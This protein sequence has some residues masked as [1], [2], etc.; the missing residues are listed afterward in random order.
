V[1]I[2]EVSMVRADVIDA[3]DHSLRINGNTPHLPFG[4]KQMIFVGDLFQL[5]PII[6]E[7]SE[8]DYI[9]KTYQYP[10][11]FQAHAFKDFKVVPIELDQVLK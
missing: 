6:K 3:I 10:Y 11:F 9:K 5:E 1:I 4:G 8:E 2:D 7:K